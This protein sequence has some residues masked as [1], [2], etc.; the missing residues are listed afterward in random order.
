[1]LE[2]FTAYDLS[3]VV[4]KSRDPLNYYFFMGGLVLYVPGK[5]KQEMNLIFV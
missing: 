2:W 4:E 3:A 5:V 1:M